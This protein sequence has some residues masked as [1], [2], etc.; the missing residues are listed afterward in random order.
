MS[1]TATTTAR[2]VQKRSLRYF[3]LEFIFHLIVNV[4]GER[5]CFFVLLLLHAKGQPKKVADH[6]GGR[7]TAHT[8]CQWATMSGTKWAKWHS[9]YFVAQV[10]RKYSINQQITQ[11]YKPLIDN[12][13]K[14]TQSK[15][16]IA[17][18]SNKDYHGSR[19]RCIASK[20]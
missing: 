4:V 6:Q 3:L 8:V 19:C 20:I 17:Y 9:R 16:G 18:G 12:G 11:S 14:Y 13:V 15:Q 1:P 2:I 10:R 7:V 5:W